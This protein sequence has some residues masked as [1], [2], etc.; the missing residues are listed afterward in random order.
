MTISWTSDLWISPSF[1]RGYFGRMPLEMRSFQLL[2]CQEIVVH[3]QQQ[4]KSLKTDTWNQGN[5][6]K[7]RKVSVKKN[8]FLLFLSYYLFSR[9]SEFS[10]T[11]FVYSFKVTISVSSYMFVEIDLLSLELRY[12]IKWLKCFISA[13]FSIYCEANN[14][15]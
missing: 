3:L 11:V 1:V 13:L 14:I 8:K 12:F 10:V 9:Q 4:H 6:K 2:P 15:K 7:H 5:R